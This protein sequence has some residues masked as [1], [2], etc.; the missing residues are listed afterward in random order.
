MDMI[1][2]NKNILQQDDDLLQILDRG[3]DDM[4]ADRELPLDEAFQ[5]I[6]ELRN[7]RRNARA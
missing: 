3:I 4:E 5:K 2:D 6:T 7:I 1:L